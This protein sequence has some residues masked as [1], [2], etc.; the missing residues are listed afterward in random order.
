MCIQKQPNNQCWGGSLRA[1]CH[2][3]RGACHTHTL[4][5]FIIVNIIKAGGLRRRWARHLEAVGARV[6]PALPVPTAGDMRA[7]A[8]VNM[9]HTAT[10]CPTVYSNVSTAHRSAWTGLIRSRGEGL[11]FAPALRYAGPCS[12]HCGRYAGPG[13]AAG[14][15][16]SRVSCWHPSSLG[17]AIAPQ[18]VHRKHGTPTAR[19][20]AQWAVGD[21]MGR[22]GTTHVTAA[23]GRLLGASGPLLERCFGNQISYQKFVIT[24]PRR[25]SILNYFSCLI[26]KD[27]WTSTDRDILPRICAFG[28]SMPHNQA[29]PSNIWV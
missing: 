29:T 23:R 10:Q 18:T 4:T 20:M 21:H 28:I 3:R 5:S 7:T 22:H 27:I 15:A 26:L 6:G 12:R 2:H 1:A 13:R 16:Y 9:T 19:L 25:V 17:P 8:R 11:L 14:T 24:V